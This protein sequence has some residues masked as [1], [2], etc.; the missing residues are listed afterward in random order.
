MRYL[1]GGCL[2]SILTLPRLAPGA[3]SRMDTSC[4]PDALIS[5]NS[6][7]R[8]TDNSGWLLDQ[9]LDVR[10][11]RAARENDLMGRETNGFG[12]PAEPRPAAHRLAADAQGGADYE[13][14]WIFGQGP[15]TLD[16]RHR[17]LR[18]QAG[19]SI[20]TNVIVAPARSDSEGHQKTVWRDCCDSIRII[21]LHK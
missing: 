7:S 1:V 4:P 8:R 10:E 20:S 11:Q 18:Y 13:R 3:S 16:Q 2:A 19:W 12:Q 17:R 15:H 6:N 21:P 14:S 5:H 9:L